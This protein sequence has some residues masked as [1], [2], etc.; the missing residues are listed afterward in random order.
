[1]EIPYLIGSD[2]YSCNQL[3]YNG[4]QKIPYL[5]QDLYDTAIA[6]YII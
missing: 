2:L 6:I 1:M 3:S 5:M 4:I